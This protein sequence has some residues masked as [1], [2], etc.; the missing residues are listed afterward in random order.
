MQPIVS[1]RE[2]GRIMAQATI[3]AGSGKRSM[4]PFMVF[5]LKRKKMPILSVTSKLLANR[6]RRPPSRATNH[7]R[8][9]VL[10]PPALQLAAP[11]RPA[12]DWLNQLFL[13]YTGYDT[14]RRKRRA[15]QRDFVP[16]VDFICQSKRKKSLAK[17]ISAS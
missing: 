9:Q 4:S 6:S 12:L 14:S 11:A 17:A 10:G 3:G 5:L 2:L 15:S 8:T 1:V 16:K 13:E 7:C